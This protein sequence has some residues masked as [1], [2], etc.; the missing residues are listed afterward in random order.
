[1]TTVLFLGAA[2]SQIPPIRY[3]RLAGYRIVTCDNRPSNPGHLLADASYNVSTTDLESVLR[4]ARAERVDGVVAYASDPAAPT[5]AYVAE[6]LGLPGNPYESVLTLTEKDRFRS[7]LRENGFRAPLSDSFTE[8][9]AGLEWFRSLASPAFLKPV[10]S[11]GSKGVS[12]VESDDQFAAAFQHA[13][14]YSRSGRVI[15][16]MEIRRQGLQVAGDGFVREGR[17]AFRCWADEHFDIECNGL[18]PIGQTFPTV[19]PDDQQ[20]VAHGETQRLLSLLGITQGALNF[21]FVFDDSGNFHFLELGPRNGGCRIPEA[22]LMGTGVDM[23]SRTVEVAIHGTCEA[24]EFQP[25]VGYWSTYMVHSLAPGAFE[26][27]RI[28]DW[29]RDRIVDLDLWVKPGDPVR[30][31]IGSDDTLGAAILQFE[32]LES[33]LAAIDDMNRHIQVLVSPSSA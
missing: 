18:V 4:I 1:M 16:E 17:L 31:Y 12:R 20:T 23:I 27:L 29:M 32:S 13:R 8:E 7:F 26:S 2:S 14:R 15:V 6:R 10:D 22:V 9:G 25:V 19:R 30:R 11:S 24:L 28:T 3:A 21:D 5:A 33:M